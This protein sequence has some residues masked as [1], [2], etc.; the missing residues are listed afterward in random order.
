M[1]TQAVGATKVAAGN[2][3]SDDHQMG[4]TTL[5]DDFTAALS[6]QRQPILVVQRLLA[7]QAG[8]ELTT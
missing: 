5:L 4:G 3:G 1:A 8:A 2:K 6:R 7:G